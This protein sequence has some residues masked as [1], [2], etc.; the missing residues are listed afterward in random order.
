MWVMCVGFGLGQLFR[1][2]YATLRCEKYESVQFQI[3]ILDGW[4]AGGL[5]P[6]I[7]PEGKLTN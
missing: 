1:S 3:H 7:V 5:G 4:E 2:N 6:Y